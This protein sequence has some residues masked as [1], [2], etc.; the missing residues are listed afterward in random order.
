MTEKKAKEDHWP[1][2]KGKWETR[3]T[4]LPEGVIFVEELASDEAERD[5]REGKEKKSTREWGI[6]VQG[7]GVG[8]GPVCYLLK[9]SR[10]GAGPGMGLCCT[11]FCLVRVKSLRETVNSQLKN[12]WLLQS[13]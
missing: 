11:H 9:T 8:R 5:G 10:V 7:K 13:Q 3:E 1:T 2:M 4:P 12:C 6:V